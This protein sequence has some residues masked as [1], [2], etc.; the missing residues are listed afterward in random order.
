MIGHL[1][2]DMTTI[3]GAKLYSSGEHF[4]HRL[5]YQGQIAAPF[6]SIRYSLLKAI[7]YSYASKQTVSLHWI[8]FP[9]YH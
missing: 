1:D 7:A 2:H 8:Q 6:K 5:N 3:T 9:L 4:V